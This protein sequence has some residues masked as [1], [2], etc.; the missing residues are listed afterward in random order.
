[1]VNSCV[2][3]LSL[4]VTVQFLI[5]FNLLTQ[6]NNTLNV[7]QNL[8]LL[9]IGGRYKRE[10]ITT[11]PSVSTLLPSLHSSHS[12]STSTSTIA[13]TPSTSNSAAITVVAV[14]LADK[15]RKTV[16]DGVAVTL[17]LHAPRWFQRR[18]TMMVLNILNNLPKTWALQI[19]YSGEGQSK[20]GI[21][22]SLGLKRLIEGG[23]V[24][25]TRIAPAVLNERKKR[26]ELMYHPWIWENMVAD[27][28]LVFGGN[29]VMCTNS[30]Q[31]ISSFDAYD[32][33]GSPWDFK[34]GV[35]GDGG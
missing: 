12:T 8:K 3:L 22:I 14:E 19:F 26:F 15:Q 11:L 20:D 27:R 25:L 6:N 2:T 34:N 32:Y 7:Q 24:I 23:H 18:Y 31:N 35:G 1:M 10:D 33:L 13:T 30:P 21:E 28:V 5:I 4:V 17:L 16:Y 29:T 9:T